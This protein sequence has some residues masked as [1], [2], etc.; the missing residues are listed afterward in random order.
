MELRF[1]LPLHLAVVA[2]EKIM[3]IPVR[4]HWLLA[5]VASG[6]CSAAIVAAAGQT[7]PAA[8]GPPQSQTQASSVDAGEKVFAANCARC[9][10]PPMTL[11][12][13]VTGTIVDHMRVRA[14]LSSKDQQLLLKFL[15]P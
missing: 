14:R 3:S 13:R 7:A 5:I 2:G 1:H 8:K 10:T 4:S 11:S 12:P 6:A 9:H 15:A